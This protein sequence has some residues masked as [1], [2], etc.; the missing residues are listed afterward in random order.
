MKNLILFFSVLIISFNT[1]SQINESAYAKM[2][3]ASLEANQFFELYGIS[4]EDL[5]NI[6]GSPYDENYFQ[7]GFIY[8]NNELKA[9]NVPMRYNIFSDDIE[10]NTSQD[11]NKQDI[12]VLSKSPDVFVKIGTDVFVYVE[13]LSDENQSGYFKVV[14][15]GDHF[16]LYKKSRVNYVEKRFAETNYQQDQPARF[17]RTDTFYLVSNRGVFYELP[18]NRR[19]FAAVFKEHNKEID[20]YVR[21]NRLDIR[22]ENDLEKIVKY[23]NTLL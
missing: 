9:S 22:N 7:L 4:I 3:N 20:T 18:T 8:S 16:D 15:E 1:Y 13:N 23:F 5:K 2:L 10:I 21:S 19:R 12:N 17:D 11:P 6:T 14:H